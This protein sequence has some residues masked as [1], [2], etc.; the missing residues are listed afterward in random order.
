MADQTTEETKEPNMIKISTLIGQTDITFKDQYLE[1][2]DAAYFIEQMT[3]DNHFRV[4]IYDNRTEKTI[5]FDP[6]ETI[7]I[8]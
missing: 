2:Y 1:T 5:T 3:P 7:R 8:I 6:N 4:Q